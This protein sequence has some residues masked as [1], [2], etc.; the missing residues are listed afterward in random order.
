MKRQYN[1]ANIRILFQYF[2]TIKMKNKK[3]NYKV[4]IQWSFT[5]MVCKFKIIQVKKKKD[6]LHILNVLFWS[7]CITF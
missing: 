7:I 6:L 4:E 1:L 5:P 2:I 3:E